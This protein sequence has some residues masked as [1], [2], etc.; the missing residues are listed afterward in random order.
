MRTW[1]GPRRRCRR[2][3]RS[4]SKPLLPPSAERHARGVVDERDAGRALDGGEGLL[5]CGF[6]VGHDPRV[7]FL[8]VPRKSFRW[9]GEAG[10][11]VGATARGPAGWSVWGGPGTDGPAGIVPGAGLPRARFFTGGWGSGGWAPLPLRT[12]CRRARPSGTCSRPS[13]WRPTDVDVVLGEQRDDGPG[14]RR[15]RGDVAGPPAPAVR[16]GCLGRSRR[17]RWRPAPGVA[18]GR[19]EAATVSDAGPRTRPVGVGREGAGELRHPG[20]EP[21]QLLQDSRPGAAA[22]QVSSRADPL[23]LKGPPAHP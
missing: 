21:A 17:P 8:L 9:W 6:G 7:V 4:W 20:P 18:P 2:R 1:R 5:Q 10:G 15:V 11:R 23:P 3:P 13:R 16:A 14:A 22:D 19:A 12:R